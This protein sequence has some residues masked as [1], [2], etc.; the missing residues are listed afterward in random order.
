MDTREN[1]KPE[2]AFDDEITI[3]ELYANSAEYTTILRRS[4]FYRRFLH[5]I[6]FI[7]LFAVQFSMNYQFIR[8]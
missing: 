2:K 7:G 3:N 5:E 4:E 1:K 6:K 8:I